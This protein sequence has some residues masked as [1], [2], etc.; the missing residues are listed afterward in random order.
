MADFEPRLA[1]S[2]QPSIMPPTG[3]LAGIDRDVDMGASVPQIHSE[4]RG[5]PAPDRSQDSSSGGNIAPVS[6]RPPSPLDCIMTDP[7]DGV[8]EAF[9]EKVTLHYRRHPNIALSS[10]VFRMKI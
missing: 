7:M 6:Q 2:S 3:L 9:M 8:P 10:A 4:R 1:L 5:A